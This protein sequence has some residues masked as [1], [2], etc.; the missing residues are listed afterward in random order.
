MIKYLALLVLRIFRLGLALRFL[1]LDL[2][3]VCVHTWVDDNN[4]SC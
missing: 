3:R 1:R 4:T 2:V